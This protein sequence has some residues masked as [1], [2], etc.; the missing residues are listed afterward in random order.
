MSKRHELHLH[1]LLP[2]SGS[3][4]LFRS[5]VWELPSV[6]VPVGKGSNCLPS[7]WH[8]VLHSYVMDHVQG[9][10]PLSWWYA[11]L[12]HTHTHTHTPILQ[13]MRASIRAMNCP[14]LEVVELASRPR[15]ANS[16]EEAF[17]NSAV[18]S[19][20]KIEFGSQKNPLVSQL[21][22]GKSKWERG[23]VS[24]GLLAAASQSHSTLK[25]LLVSS[26]PAFL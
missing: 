6:Y 13:G 25:S 5:R 14:K 12:L 1:L 17:N 24:L 16:R 9:R 26:E 22:P 15:L 10:Y 8:C 2:F 11:T 21:R 19:F 3:F 23:S 4:L 7:I 20:M 18:L